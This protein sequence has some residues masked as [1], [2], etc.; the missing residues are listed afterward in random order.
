M[1]LQDQPPLHL[2]YGL[3]IHPDETLADLE[4]S[5]R[6]HACA[7][8]DRVGPGRPFGLGL[9]ISDAV[10]RELGTGSALAR[11][12]DLLAANDLYVFT[13]NGFPFGRFRGGPVKERVYAPDWRTEE[14]VAYTL[15]L[16]DQ[17]A[18]LL[19][20]GVAGSISTVPGS[21]KAWIGGPADVDLIAANL[22]RVA[23]HVAALRDRTGREI[24]IGLEPEPGCLWETPAELVRFLRGRPWPGGAGEEI[25]RRHIGVCLDTC[26]MA[27]CFEEPE[28][29]LRKYRE[30]GIRV[31]KIQLSAALEASGAGVKELARFAEPV[32]LHQAAARWDDSRVRTW[33]DLP[34]ALAEL[35]GLPEPPLVRVHFHV[36][37]HFGGAAGLR[38]T[39]ETMTP[40]FF[41]AVRAGATEHLEI[42]TYSFDAL[43]GGPKDAVESVAAEFRWVMPRLAAGT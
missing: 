25:R 34:E 42:E 26:H 40:G 1:K 27:L 13:L 17:L 41:R 39:A 4:A 20:A 21:F 43:P 18:E 23:R 10:S 12:K 37:L 36:P 30:A 11:L 35:P 6:R 33:P 8:R 7:V 38:S 2:T 15:R 19:P 32:Y 24:H 29:V 3:S 16:A 28:A 5:I 22:G 31:S 14:R 9:R